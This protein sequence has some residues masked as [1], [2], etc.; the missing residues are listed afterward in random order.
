VESGGCVAEAGERTV[1]ARL[2]PALE[3]LREVLAS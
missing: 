3:R 2:G 1:D